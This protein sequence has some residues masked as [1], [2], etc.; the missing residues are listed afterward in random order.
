MIIG[1]INSEI[2]EHRK[3][4]KI[5]NLICYAISVYSYNL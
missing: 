2:P 5:L 3:R 1:K 4:E